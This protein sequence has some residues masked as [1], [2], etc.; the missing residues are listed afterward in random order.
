MKYDKTG[1]FWKSLFKSMSELEKD[2]W[3]HMKVYNAP[4][5][6]SMF[7]VWFISMYDWRVDFKMDIPE[8]PHDKSFFQ[9]NNR[10]GNGSLKQIC[11]NWKT[12][13]Q[14]YGKT[15]KFTCVFTWALCHMSM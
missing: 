14:Q 12:K 9:C 11:S 1:S 6:R 13:R 7:H 4:Y 5:T 2:R 10:C 3:R 8:T 15:L